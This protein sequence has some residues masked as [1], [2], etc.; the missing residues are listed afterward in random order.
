M[1]LSF[2][3]KEGIPA[4][5]G[6][7]RGKRLG[8]AE[9]K[10]EDLLILIDSSIIEIFVNQGELVFTTRIYLEKEE[11]EIWSGKWENTSLEIVEEKQ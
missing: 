1:E 4:P 6:G 2:L 7:G 9:N 11:R 10:V 5:C 8:R 3:D